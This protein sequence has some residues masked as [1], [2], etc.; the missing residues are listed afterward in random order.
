M[1][2]K[3]FCGEESMMLVFKRWRKLEKDFYNHKKQKFNISKV[4]DI[5]DSIKYDYIHNYDNLM[6][7][8]EIAEKILEDANTLGAFIVPSE[9]GITNEDKVLIGG[10]IIGNLLH[11]IKTDLIWWTTPHYRKLECEYGEG[12]GF[13][14]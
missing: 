4:P 14:S 12:G 8:K 7:F 13:F 6:E 3:M 11:K 5:L 10:H 1:K 2:E 9:Y